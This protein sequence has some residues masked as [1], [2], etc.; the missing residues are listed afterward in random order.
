MSRRRIAFL[1]TIVAVTL[2]CKSSVDNTMGGGQSFTVG[3]SA[4][5]DYAS[6][7]AAVNSRSR[8]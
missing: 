3:L 7:Q 8:R 4:A 1:M 5:A 6:I 2:A